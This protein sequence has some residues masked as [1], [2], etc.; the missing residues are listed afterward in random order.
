METSWQNPDQSDKPSDQDFRDINSQLDSLLAEKDQKYAPL[1]SRQAEVNENLGE[2][3]RTLL[4]YTANMDV[5]GMSAIVG[6]FTNKYLRLQNLGSE[7]ENSTEELAA[8]EK[9]LS[10][11][12]AD[13]RGKITSY[14]LLNADIRNALNSEYAANIEDIRV[15]LGNYDAKT[16]ALNE[17]I[18]GR[19]NLYSAL[20]TQPV[21]VDLEDSL[22]EAVKN[23]NEA[24]IFLTG[25]LLNAQFGDS[26]NTRE[27][28]ELTYADLTSNR[29]ATEYRL[30]L[31]VTRLDEVEGNLTSRIEGSEN[32]TNQAVGELKTAVEE[33]KE[34]FSEKAEQ[35]SASNG[36]RDYVRNH[37]RGIVIAGAIGLAVVAAG[38]AGAI[39]YVNN[40]I[41]SHAEDT[42]PYSL[43]LQDQRSIVSMIGTP[44]PGED[45]NLTQQDKADIAV[46]VA[47]PTSTPE[48][49]S[50]AVYATGTPEPAPTS[51]AVYAT[52]TPEPEPTATPRPTVA[53]TATPRPTVA[54]TA[55][56]RPT[57][58]PTATPRPTPRPTPIPT[59]LPLPNKFTLD[60]GALD[61]MVE[62]DGSGLTDALNLDPVRRTVYMLSNGISKGES[63][64]NMKDAMAIDQ[65]AGTVIS[66]FHK[67]GKSYSRQHE[68]ITSTAALI[69]QINEMSKRNDYC[70]REIR[71]S[72]QK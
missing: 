63:E 15:E 18:E 55:T 19:D 56:P 33:A 59:P 12:L 45:Y 23:D 42:T 24:Q 39:A 38:S 52:G 28:V 4:L 53:P 14:D 16:T 43:T 17:L 20:N 27:L 2:L 61:C 72:L 21:R 48:P 44:E 50:A 26:D 6:D 57:V 65:K 66:A 30:N 51:A 36:F 32:K 64:W 13:L 37:F 5:S 49:T 34:E 40:K 31:Q 60:Y 7:V 10:G 22:A 54:P 11:D 71:E 3:D 1:A 58:A 70:R 41:D 68:N 29:E 47:D 25:Y 35:A 9:E 62:K 67:D 69:N 8:A 46:L